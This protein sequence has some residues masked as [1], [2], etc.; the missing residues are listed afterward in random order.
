MS[1]ED[2]KLW[3]DFKKDSKKLDISSFRLKNQLNPKFWDK[4]RLKQNISKRLMLIVEEFFEELGLISSEIDDITLTGSI[5]GYN[6]SDMSDIDLHVLVDLSKIDENIDLVREYFNGKTF[7][8]NFKHNIDIYGHEVEIYVQDTNEEHVSDSIYSIK[9]DNWLVEPRQNK[10][11]IDF[12]GVKNKAT[13]LI[14]CIERIFDLYD[15]KN[16]KKALKCAKKAKEKIK[17]MRK[18]GLEEV[19]IFSIENLA[20]KVLRRNGYLGYLNDIIV[21]SY[22]K[23][24][25]LKQNFVKKLQIYVSEPKI[26]EKQGFNRI[27][28]LE[29]YQKRLKKQHFRLKNRLLGLG[30]QE[31]TPPFSQETSKK[32]AESAPPG[33]GGS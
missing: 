4:N 28:E 13:G 26:E 29:K 32:R 31:N 9:N 19:G 23:M 18:I 2:Q 16:Y 7:I 5:A 1:L 6:W 12:N 8:W 22:D 3:E 30:N 25:S 10:S 11:K 15:D 27:N 20:F 33:Y 14:D 24:R 21:N 17:K